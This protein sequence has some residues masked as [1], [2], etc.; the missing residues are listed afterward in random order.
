MRL[1]TKGKICVQ[2][3]ISSVVYATRSMSMYKHAYIA[4]DEH[5]VETCVIKRSVVVEC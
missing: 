4:L 3:V 1:A 5:L 2:C